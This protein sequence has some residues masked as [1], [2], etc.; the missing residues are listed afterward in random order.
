VSTD[1]D[2]SAR[3][4]RL[5][6][7]GTIIAKA[8]AATRYHRADRIDDA[9]LE[10][11]LCAFAEAH[12]GDADDAE[13]AGLLGV[14]ARRLLRHALVTTLTRD[15]ALE[16]VVAGACSRADIPGSEPQVAYC[17][18]V[19]C[20][21]ADPARSKKGLPRERTYKLD[22]GEAAFDEQ[23]LHWATV[24]ARNVSE[25]GEAY[26]AIFDE[27]ESSAIDTL[28]GLMS[29]GEFTSRDDVA[30][31]LAA[32]LSATLTN[33]AMLEEMSLTEARDAEP[34]GGD[35]VFQSPLGQWV[36][37]SMKRE[38]L[39]HPDPH[40]NVDVA[41]LGSDAPES[42]VGDESYEALVRLVAAL[43]AT[44]KLLAEVLETAE[45]QA[46]QTGARWYESDDDSAEFQRVRAELD[47]VAHLLRDEQRLLGQMLAY[48]VL[49]MAQSP[50]R[51]AVAILSLRVDWLEEAVRD[52]LAGRMRAVVNDDDQPVPALVIKA[53]QAH[54]RKLIPA[55]RP[56]ALRLLREDLRHRADELARLG[57][58][59]DELPPVVGGGSE[60]IAAAV[61]EQLV[62]G[63]VRAVRYAAAKELGAVDR[64]FERAFRRYAMRRQRTVRNHGRG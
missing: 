36:G 54:E 61:P 59:L 44:K 19:L 13:L 30:D 24:I 50:D 15:H 5:C 17:L 10:R 48:I 3:I 42:D 27:A 35:Y 1:S 33:G 41:E 52:D 31:V 58:I 23:L 16:E 63:S 37:T 8:R 2:R 56:R 53:E 9:Q 14:E 7:S 60:A 49:A 18:V 34:H 47:Y 28:R 20:Q 6:D 29:L 62:R 57:S 25:C 26:R 4:R 55:N 38:F 22:V 12:A 32:R 64:V 45:S 11:R 46:E 39:R 51:H 21:K 40:R 43:G